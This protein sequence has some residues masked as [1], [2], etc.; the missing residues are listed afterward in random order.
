MND[1]V[2]FCCPWRDCWRKFYSKNHIEKHLSTYK[3]SDIHSKE[4][5]IL[6]YKCPYINC[7]D[8]KSTFR[9]LLQHISSHSLNRSSQDILSF[10][11]LLSLESLLN[12]TIQIIPS[13]PVIS[14]K[15]SYILKPISITEWT[16][17]H[18]I[19]DIMTKFIDLHLNNDTKMI[20]ISN[21]HDLK[22]LLTILLWEL[23]PF[24]F[25]FLTDN[26]FSIKNDDIRSR[27]YLS[28]W[29]QHYSEIEDSC[30]I[31]TF[32]RKRK[33]LHSVHCI[34]PVTGCH[35]NLNSFMAFQYHLRHHI[36]DLIEIARSSR[37]M[38]S[39]QVCGIQFSI[40][41]DITELLSRTVWFIA[42]LVVVEPAVM[43]NIRPFAFSFQSFSKYY[44]DN[45]LSFHLR[46]ELNQ[47]SFISNSDISEIIDSL[48]KDSYKKLWS[49]SNI[50][51]PIDTINDQCTIHGKYQ[52]HQSIYKARLFINDSQCPILENNIVPLGDNQSIIY[53]MSSTIL[54]MEWFP[55]AL[56]NENIKPILTVAGNDNPGCIPHY[57]RQEYDVNGKTSIYFY[58][59]APM[60]NS[61]DHRLEFTFTIPTNWISQ[62]SWN[63][64]DSNFVLLC[65][66][67]SDGAIYIRKLSIIDEF[68]SRELETFNDKISISDASISTFQWDKDKE[69]IIFG[70]ANG[71]I[72]IYTIKAKS[73]SFLVACHA[74]VVSLVVPHPN[75]SHIFLSTAYDGSINLWDMNS[76]Y[77]PIP[78]RNIR[79][80]ITS[81]QWLSSSKNHID[82]TPVDDM[83]IIWTED[84]GQNIKYAN[85]VDPDIITTL[86]TMPKGRKSKEPTYKISSLQPDPLRSRSVINL[87]PKHIGDKYLVA[88]A[89]WMGHIELIGIKNSYN[90]KRS[91]GYCERPSYYIIE[92]ESLC[93]IS[94]VSIDDTVLNIS[95][96]LHDNSILSKIKKN[97]HEKIV[98]MQYDTTT[99]LSNTIDPHPSCINLIKWHPSCIGLLASSS[100]HGFIHIYRIK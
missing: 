56:N 94:S 93:H 98:K 96:Y 40:D 33:S 27:E 43:D 35:R 99:D 92:Q 2:S 53:M 78:I 100:I 5:S 49:F 11:E 67:Q 81:L 6:V 17:N 73:I 51:V 31:E 12:R 18:N 72:G 1:I 55:I 58:S 14:E 10:Y 74:S 75:Q 88:S 45:Y 57:S 86:N 76:L 71:H 20:S 15:N 68:N 48:P 13:V 66:L 37:W 87:Y 46:P 90:P 82:Q 60:S 50:I 63:V 22:S 84:N 38:K 62:L 4:S 44:I 19:D 25:I 16:M 9:E 70:T 32:E 61:I 77:K 26:H 3:H 59:I 34:C 28:Q 23:F 64:I 52:H 80:P 41:E 65:T 36:H 85:I 8:S 69:K 79:S 89:S 24:G 21:E 95:T 47:A 7:S 30:I 54:C 97:I 29:K 91:K 42:D 39:H 83:T